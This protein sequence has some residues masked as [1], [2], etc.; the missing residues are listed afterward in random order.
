MAASPAI[1]LFSGSESLASSSDLDELEVSGS[2][3]R[4]RQLLRDSLR[5]GQVGVPHE[6]A[7]H[8]LG[9]LYQ[10]LNSN[11]EAERAYR[12]AL[13][14]NPALPSTLN[15]LAVLRMA[16]LD[17]PSADHW[18]SAG[19][20]LSGIQAYE[21]CLLLNSA[22]EL[23]L[24]QCRPLQARS[25]AEEQLNLLDRPRARV[26]LSLSLRALNDLEG[27]LH[28]LQRALEQW[29]TTR[30]LDDDALL[31][32]I[33]RLRPEGLTATIQFHLTLMNFA[34]ARLSIN[35]LDRKAQ[36]LLLA[37]AGIEPFSWADCS[38]FARLWRGQHVEE[39]VLWHDQGY[40]DAIQNLA[41]IEEISQR[42][43]RLRLF[44]RA[45]LL[46]V[47]QQRMSLPRNC[48]VEVMDPL[49]PPWQLGTAHLGL[50]FVPL[51]LGGWGPDQSPLQR[52]S[53]SRR[54]DA[55]DVAQFP[56]IGLVWMAGRHQAPQ[57]ELAAR[58]RDLPFDHIKQR[59]RIWR[60]RFQAHC[61][62]LQLDIDHP[63]DGPSRELVDQGMLSTPLTSSGDW[64]DTLQVVEK[65]DLVLTV[66]T[67]MAHL[68][69]ALGVPCVVLLN[70]PCDWR[71]GQSGERTFLYDSLRL[72]R[73]PVPHA[74]DQAML[75]AD[76]WIAEWLS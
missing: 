31:Q 65:M 67:A 26:N 71:W 13:R 16:V 41:W 12:L 35:S 55:V 44:V 73:C 63:P 9:R 72:A 7:L 36:Q 18:L 48:Q 39:L 60:Q 33:G 17:Y 14:L 8:R 45:S 74:W 57:P 49:C 70:A 54:S 59:I 46:R 6:Q 62:S 38:F 32:S 23:R 28:H 68:C 50:W 40:G 4:A 42:V 58:M 51:M 29:L 27:A 37:G 24:Y 3:A 47:V 30:T 25:L 53:L 20:A 1:I 19:L 22:C 61:F 76:R 15:N 43:D 69:G 52:C 34:V 5:S 21:R 56:R 75:S 10:R 11:Q 66:D 64:L 2:F